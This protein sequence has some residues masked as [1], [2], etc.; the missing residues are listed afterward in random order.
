MANFGLVASSGSGAPGG[1]LP[2]ALNIS[3]IRNYDSNRVFRDLRFVDH[4][5]NQ[6]FLKLRIRDSNN[7]ESFWNPDSWSFD[8]IEIEKLE[9][10]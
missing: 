5:T 8:F 6:T 4:D 7:Y 9:I 1:L 2:G 3:R 10:Y